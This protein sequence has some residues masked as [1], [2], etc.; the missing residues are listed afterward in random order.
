MCVC[1][2]IYKYIHRYIEGPASC[3]PYGIGSVFMN[4]NSNSECTEVT[5]PLQWQCSSE[6]EEE[7]LQ[8]GGFVHRVTGHHSRQEPCLHDLS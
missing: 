3:S 4:L 8:G 5:K 6:A 2:Y 7:N 1:I